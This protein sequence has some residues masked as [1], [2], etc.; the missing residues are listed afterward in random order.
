[1]DDANSRTKG[2]RWAPHF[3][4]SLLYIAWECVPRTRG[5]PARLV[6]RW[7]EAHPNTPSTASALAQRL[8]RIK[9][10]GMVPS[11]Q[12]GCS[13]EPEMLRLVTVPPYSAPPPPPP[14]QAESMCHMFCCRHEEPMEPNNNSREKK[15]SRLVDIP[16]RERSGKPQEVVEAEARTKIL[17]LLADMDISSPGPQPFKHRTPIATRSTGSPSCTTDRSS[18]QHN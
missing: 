10:K 17:T 12:A 1:M 5:F 6:E 13:H 4:Q 14:P 8:T 15:R 3:T 16:A 2:V 11:Q 18:G 7:N 9:R